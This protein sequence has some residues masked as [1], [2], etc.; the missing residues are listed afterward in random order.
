MIETILLARTRA[1]SYV[2]LSKPG[3]DWN[4]LTAALHK[5]DGDASAGAGGVG[6]HVHDEY[7]S[8]GLFQLV[9]QKKVRRF[10][11]KAQAAQARAVR[12]A[13]DAEFRRAEALGKASMED[14]RELAAELKI[15]SVTVRTS[16][17][18]LVA[19]ILAARKK[20]SPLTAK[21]AENAEKGKPG[22]PTVAEFVAAG[23]NPANYP[24]LGY[25]PISS[26]EEVAAAVAEYK[27]NPPSG[28]ASAAD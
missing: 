22:G 16:R 24:P 23:Y 19:A 9:P 13:Q 27:K 8:V 4:S 2:A 17:S 6:E 15:A 18:E 25:A 1:G 26:P 3:A 12:S 7:E 5:L 10:A 20:G 21:S 28:D 14:L 11:T